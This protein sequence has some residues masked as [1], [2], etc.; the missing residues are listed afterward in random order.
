MDNIL[1]CETCGKT[2]RETAIV[3]KPVRFAFL[4]DIV[5]MEQSTDDGRKQENI[6]L[7]CLVEEIERLKDNCKTRY[8]ITFS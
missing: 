1:S 3:E 2:C 7:D 6:C 8:T 5:E 4:S